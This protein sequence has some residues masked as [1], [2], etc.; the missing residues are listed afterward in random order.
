MSAVIGD[1]G[2]AT[3]IPKPDMRLP[4]VNKAFF[5]FANYFFEGIFNWGSVKDSNVLQQFLH[6]KNSD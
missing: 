1:F 2:L 6:T 4:Q 5:H 3:K